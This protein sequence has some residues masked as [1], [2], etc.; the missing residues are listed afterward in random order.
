MTN[1]LA[2]KYKCVIAVR[3]EF[4]H[5]VASDVPKRVET[6]PQTTSER[7]L[8]QLDWLLAQAAL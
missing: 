4:G 2:N 5:Y 8:A 3:Y 1:E 7:A 6:D